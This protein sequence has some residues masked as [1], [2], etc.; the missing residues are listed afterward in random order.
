MACTA[1]LV[2]VISTVNG[3]IKKGGKALEDAAQQWAHNKTE[4]NYIL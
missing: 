3:N 2:C 4:A 1:C